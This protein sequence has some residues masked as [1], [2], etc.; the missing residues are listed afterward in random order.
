MS[1]NNA[2]QETFAADTSGRGP[3]EWAAGLALLFVGLTIAHL[4][5]SLF[6]ISDLGTDTFT[7]LV[8]GISRTAGLSIGTCHVIMLILLMAVMLVTTKGYIK[9]GSVVCAFCGGWIIDFFLWV[10]GD[11]V[12]SA[13]PFWL[14]LVMMLLGCVILSLGMSVVIASNSGTGP[15]DLIA[16]IL[17]DKLQPIIHAQFRWVR[18]GCDVVFVAAGYLLGG[19][20][21]IGTVAAALLVGPMVQFFLPK[22]RAAARRLLKEN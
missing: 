16:I 13:S 18:I 1:K 15:N 11:R 6:L 17:T 14:R 12:N 4:G 10:F 19:V 21:G 2:K 7:I 8:Q 22:S 9:P 3:K 20:L 5:V